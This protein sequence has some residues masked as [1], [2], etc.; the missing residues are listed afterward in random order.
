M[1][2][3]RIVVVTGA[4]SG[5]GA[6]TVAYLRK[7]GCEV[8]GVDL[9]DAK[10]CADLESQSGRAEAATC[11]RELA[12]D[13]LDAVILCAGIGGL[14]K[15]A[16]AITSINFFGTTRL[17]ALLRPQLARGSDPRVVVVSS[18]MA[19]LQ[20]DDRLLELCLADDEERARSSSSDPMLAYSTGKRALCHWV[21]SMAVT[22]EW[23][24]S[25]ILLNGIAP[26]VVA[27]PLT[28]A[29]LKTAEGRQA[30]AAAAP[31]VLPDYPTP[32][33]LAPLIAFLASAENG[34]MVGQ[35]IHCDG[36]TE[37]ILRGPAVPR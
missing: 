30:A 33:V 11:I 1:K 27:T 25:R 8:I 4:A 36:G 34:N 31:I 14:D 37:V 35:I 24:G 20:V 22:D 7:A 5:I 6:A 28:Q 13:G 16:D 10:I 9:A 32:D 19:L 12:P 26:G 2:G 18:S 29:R 23:C 21:R 15:K 3:R 17:L